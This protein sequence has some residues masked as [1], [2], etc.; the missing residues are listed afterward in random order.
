MVKTG[1]GRVRG[2]GEGGAVVFRGLPYAA[3]PEGPRRFLPPAPP[4]GWDGVREATVFGTAPPQPPPAPQVPPVWKPGDGLGCLTLNVW[5]PEVGSTGLPVMV[6]L[7]GGMWRYGWTGM[8][9]YDAATLAEGGVVVVTVDYRLGF[10]GFGH[11]PGVPGNRGL[12]DQIAALHWV[13]DNITAFGGD[14]G[15]VTIF[16]QSAGAA[17]VA[18]L[19]A[20]PSAEGLFHRVIAQS[21]PDGYL[22]VAEAEQV[23]RTLAEAAGVSATWAGMAELPPEALLAV[24]PSGDAPGTN[25]FG[26]VIDGDLVTGPP[27]RGPRPDVDLIC[28]FTHEE[29]RGIAPGL[30]AS[31]IDL[32]VAAA[33]LG[34][35]PDAA[36]AYRRTYSGGDGPFVAMMSDALVRMP[37]TW[38][39]E[40]H[41]EA[42][43]RTWLYDITWQGPTLGAAHGI[44]VPLTF[45]NGDTRFAARLLGSPP[46]PTFT[47]L[48]ER[49]RTAWT[50]FATTGD[51]GWPRFQPHD[52]R[53]RLW[54]I[55]PI[56]AP[57]PLT[58]SR[59]LWPARTR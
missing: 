24:P 26:P 14:P 51:P 30:D 29:F 22:S 48:S 58:E 1:L 39:A 11:L 12:R 10:E 28:G 52:R 6:W 53:T 27:G 32:T 44:D 2:L 7:Y 36:D 31:G 16:G 8:P 49:I 5:S 23:T 20:T 37:T 17:S 46:P 41:A 38:V 18:L 59:R 56:N 25:P 45:G 47:A 57:Y 50:S 43:G 35:G 15:R 9:Q 3:A 19:A 13:Q 34:L 40:A 33:R 21:I 55:E 42:G 4:E 54:D